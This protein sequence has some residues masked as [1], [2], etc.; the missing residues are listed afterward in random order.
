[1]GADLLRPRTQRQLAAPADG[2]PIASPPPLLSV[3]QQSDAA[4]CVALQQVDHLIGLQCQH[5]QQ[6]PSQE[7]YQAAQLQPCS[8]RPAEYRPA[9]GRADG[10]KT[11]T[12]DSYDSNSDWDSAE[13]EEEGEEVEDSQLVEVE[14]EQSVAQRLQSC[15]AEAGG[16]DTSASCAD[17]SSE[18]EEGWEDCLDGQA[19]Q[20][21]AS[22]E[23]LFDTFWSKLSPLVQLCFAQLFG[24]QEQ[25]S[26]SKRRSSSKGVQPPPVCGNPRCRRRGTPQPGCDVGGIPAGHVK[27]KFCTTDGPS[28]RLVCTC[29]REQDIAKVGGLAAASLPS[30]RR[31]RPRCRCTYLVD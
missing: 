30:I 9:H 24:V 29:Q 27:P 4:S 3:A 10:S 5:R 22:Q 31:A 28:V 12:A 13:E 14:A 23:D 2:A 6:Q 7:Q 20:D 18:E 26:S 19:E 1:M 21:A 15:G 17:M 8:L 16:C 25:R 11:P